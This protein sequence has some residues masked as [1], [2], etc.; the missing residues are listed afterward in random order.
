MYT[1]FYAYIDK[2]LEEFLD[3]KNLDNPLSNHRNSAD[4]YVEWGR[5][6]S[7]M[8]L[9]NNITCMEFEGREDTISSVLDS[10]CKTIL[11]PSAKK[12][13]Y[14]I[15]A[16]PG[17]GKTRLFL[18]MVRMGDEERKSYLSKSL[19]K[20]NKIKL[21]DDF[22]HVAI[23]FN[24]CTYY[25]PMHT[26]ISDVSDILS[27]VSLRIMHIWL[28]TVAIEDLFKVITTAKKAGELTNDLLSF[29]SVISIV[30]R[31]A[32]R[33]RIV[34]FID[35]I[36]KMDDS[37]VMNQLVLRLSAAQDEESY[38]LR[39]CYSAL[40]VDIFERV[41]AYSGRKIIC[42]PLPLIHEDATRSIS[43]KVANKET[44]PRDGETQSNEMF[45]D[46]MTQLSGGHMRALET[47][48][49][50]FEDLNRTEDVLDLIRKAGRHYSTLYVTNIYAAVVLSLL[51]SPIKK[52]ATVNYL[53]KSI[54]VD[55]MVAS[56]RL[57]ASFE[58]EQSEL[59]VLPNMPPLSLIQWAFQTADNYNC[60]DKT[61]EYQVANT[62]SNIVQEALATGAMTGKKF[63]SVCIRRH[64]LMRHVYKSVMEG[65]VVE[66]PTGV[67][68]RRAT[69]KDYF[70][71]T[72]REG[73][74]SA[75]LAD[76]TFDFTQLLPSKWEMLKNNAAIKTFFE[77]NYAEKRLAV[78]QPTNPNF[79]AIDYFLCLVS[80]CGVVVTLV[81][82]S[83]FSSE[84][85][86]TI[87]NVGGIEKTLKKAIDLTAKF[88]VP[89]NTIICVAELWRVPPGTGAI[90]KPMSV[91]NT[92]CQTKRELEMQAGP[93]MT[94]LMA[95]ADI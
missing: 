23:S 92:I 25:N 14:F 68:W 5:R 11:K 12:P 34:L 19:D 91:E 90:D 3:D 37:E 29:K 53:G 66:N 77:K 49:T 60:K 33:K 2:S 39:V 74:I 55:D 32:S 95:L 48:A 6:R 58:N 35:E 86:T 57:M 81:F 31:R 54:T 83:K 59:K 80:N 40:K 70:K 8:V 24:G 30:L 50:T 93:L 9:M 51:A 26:K 21:I 28:S 47:L 52:S 88:R 13:V 46:A 43:T 36:L 85:S 72:R 69:L 64:I 73:I 75:E 16:S 56:G 62:I 27:H 65:N 87:V 42:T 89:R 44:R 18:E 22:L 67:D 45:I 71:Y 15:H 7:E 41:K 1:H 63:E 61:S 84:D 94:D 17:M 76:L 20:E 4:A 38:S 82:Q 79:K 78:G 10:V